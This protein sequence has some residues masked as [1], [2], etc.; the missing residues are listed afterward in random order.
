MKTKNYLFMVLCLISTSLFSQI[1]TGYYDSAAGLSG[2]ALKTKLS[3]IITNGHVDKGYAGLWTAYKTTDID[4]NYENDGSILDMYSENPSGTDP[5]KFIVTTDQCGT[6]SVEGDCYNREHVV[7]QSLFNQAAPMVSDLHHI[8]ATDGKVNG[9]RSNYPFGKVGTATFTS[10]NGGK[11]GNSVSSG[12][13]GTV[14]EPIDEFKGDIARMIF[15]FVTRYESKLSG[16]ST[17]NM[18]GTSTYPG[19]QTWE[20]DVLLAWHNLDPVSQAEINRNNASYTFQGN[21]NP[22][23]DKPEYVAL[24]WGGTSTD[25]TAPTVPTNLTASS[26]TTTSATVSW[27][28][29]TD[30]IGVTGYKVFRNGTQVGTSTS[31]SYNLTGLTAGTTYSITAQAY[32]AAGNSSASST[33]LSLT[34]TNNTSDTTAPSVPSGLTSSSITQ[35]SATVSWTASTDNV[36]VTGYKIF[37]NGTQVGTSTSTSYG[38][39]GLTAGTTYS[40][41]V[42]A[43]DAAA[44]SSA[45]S[46]ALSLTTTAAATFTELY[47]SEYLEGSSNNKAIEISNRTGSSIALSAYYI[48]KQVNGSTTWT[49]VATLSGTLANNTT[50]VVAHSSYA[51]TCGGTIN[52]KTTNLDFNGNDTVGLF[53][54]NVLIDII[55][56]SGSSANFALD[57]T[58]RRNVSKPRTTYL[59]SEWTSYSVDTCTNI[60]TVNPTGTAR[61]MPNQNLN[62]EISI[63]PNPVQNKEVFFKGNIQGVENVKVYDMNGKLVYE[64]VKPFAKTNKLTLKNLP[65][66]NYIITY[67]NQSQKLIIE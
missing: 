59:A 20:R 39:T 19:L 66:G 35:T 9:M 38:L 55:G 26:I 62:S 46:T 52:L 4:K 33:A 2:A 40:I 21:R 53:K 30:N 49:A 14:F 28:A 47:F 13:T 61:M 65:K 24:I 6:Y 5:Y 36:G 45:S 7:P 27:T 43:Y 15:Y 63:Y 18:L 12:Y 23:I 11:L 48:K 60:G 41:T 44:N 67:D 25:T 37:R 22:F 10:R 8:R 29:S 31:T 34:T 42:Q 16:F 17:G 3:T 50:Y 64:A 56:T 1:P 57:V 32:D 58:L 54:N 51:L